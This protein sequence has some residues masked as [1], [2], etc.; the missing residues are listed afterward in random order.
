MT[1]APIWRD[2]RRTDIS[3]AIGKERTMINETTLAYQV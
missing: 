3:V 2:T 1:S